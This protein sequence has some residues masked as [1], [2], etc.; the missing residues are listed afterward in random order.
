MNDKIIERGTIMT[1]WITS[2]ASAASIISLASI[3][4]LPIWGRIIITVLGLAS[5]AY[6]LYQNIRSNQV[7]K[8]VCHSEEEIKSVMIRLIRTQGRVCIMSRDLSWVDDEVVEC[9]KNKRG[10]VLIFASE[11]TELTKQLEQYGAELKY[12]G[13]QFEPKSRFTITRFNRDNYQVAVSDSQDSVRRN[14]QFTHEIYQTAR[15]N[16]CEQDKWIDSLALDMINLCRAFC[17]DN[18]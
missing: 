17:K 6:L 10:N 4:G 8:I 9:I 1:Q 2:I 11:E 14:T 12:Y 3:K 15:Y 7:N 16:N 5:L 13:T 18:Q